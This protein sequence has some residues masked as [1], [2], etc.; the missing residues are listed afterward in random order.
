MIS[1]EER[2][3][4]HS[5]AQRGGRGKARGW[6]PSTGQPEQPQEK[7]TGPHLDPRLPASTA[8]S[9]LRLSQLPSLRYV[10]W[11]P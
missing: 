4:G 5:Q 8:E 6:T 1:G 11:R 7:Q 10:V 2:R 9:P 3:A